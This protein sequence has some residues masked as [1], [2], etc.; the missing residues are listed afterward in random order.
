MQPAETL[1]LLSFTA[2]LCPLRIQ[3]CF[4]LSTDKRSLYS[5]IVF[6]NLINTISDICFVFVS[7]FIISWTT[8]V[9]AFYA[10]HTAHCLLYGRVCCRPLWHDAG[11]SKP[12]SHRH[13]SLLDTLTY[14]QHSTFLSVNQSRTKNFEMCKRRMVVQSLRV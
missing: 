3:H 4:Y 11:W 14:C 9:N 6:F 5:H 7:G 1:H 10:P 13:I 2:S 8:A 12:K